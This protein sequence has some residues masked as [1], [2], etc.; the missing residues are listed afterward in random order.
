MNEV[1]YAMKICQLEKAK[2]EL[3]ALMSLWYAFDGYK[4]EET[5]CSI[6]PIIENFIKGLEDYCG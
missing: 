1:P 2:G 3:N 5:Y 4:G 6:K